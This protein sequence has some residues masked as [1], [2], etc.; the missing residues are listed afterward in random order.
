MRSTGTAPTL[1]DGSKVIHIGMPKTGTT[2]LQTA[3]DAVR[4]QIAEDGVRLIGKGRHEMKTALAAAG[5]LAPYYQDR[6]EERWQELATNFRTSDSRVTI[7]SSEA[8]SQ[9]LPERIPHIA[10]MLGPDVHVVITL[11]PLA[12]LL[13]SQWQEVIRRRGLETLD[14]W[15]RRHF[16]WVSLDG[17]VH[18]TWTRVMPELHR[19]SLRRLV[20]QWGSVFGE[21]RL[22]FIVSD[23]RDRTTNQRAFEALLGLGPDTLTAEERANASLPIAEAELLRQFNIAFTERDGDHPTYMN[24]V[25]RSGKLAMRELTGLTGQPI[26]APR[27]AAERCNDYT[28]TWIEAVEASDATVVGDLDHLLVDPADYPEDISP[29]DSISVTSAGLISELLFESG[30]HHVPESHSLPGL[31][32]YP[33]GD[34]VRE[35]ARRARQRVGRRR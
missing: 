29:P 34:L 14:E 9:A 3:L 28:R 27:W 24:T 30:L 16:S 20:E 32:R 22:T 18:T 21:D 19:F 35:L 31:D 15:L 33:G 8:L 23:P 10:E 12:P 7:W 17:E 13:A 2:A 4:E 25:S 11:R 6:R 5:T 26:Q 1:P